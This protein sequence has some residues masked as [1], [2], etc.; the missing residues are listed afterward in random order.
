[1]AGGEE[2]KIGSGMTDPEQHQGAGKTP[3]LSG[4]TWVKIWLGD[5]RQNPLPLSEPH[6]LLICKMAI[7][8]PASQGGVK[9]R[10]DECTPHASKP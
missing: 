5:L 2:G 1:M 6:T 10:N 9:K 7:I 4:K 3:S 8:I